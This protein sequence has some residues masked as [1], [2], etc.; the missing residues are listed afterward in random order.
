M[1]SAS[2]PIYLR[3]IPVIN[4]WPASGHVLFV[5]ITTILA[6]AFTTAPYYAIRGG[7]AISASQAE[8]S[9]GFGRP[10][11]PPSQTPAN[12]APSLTTALART[13]F[14]DKS[15]PRARRPAR[16]PAKFSHGSAHNAITPDTPRPLSVQEKLP[17]FPSHKLHHL[18]PSAPPP[19]APRSLKKP[20]SANTRA[21]RRGALRLADGLPLAGQCRVAS[22]RGYHHRRSPRVRPP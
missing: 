11:P 15:S 14:S 16:P 3:E 8:Q 1:I 5:R 18:P 4:L 2:D 12:A 21:R 17:A 6:A 7:L 19:P 9:P 10:T 20:R 22:E 13:S